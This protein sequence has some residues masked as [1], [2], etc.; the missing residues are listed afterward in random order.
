ME[1]HSEQM[2]EQVRSLASWC[3][4]QAEQPQAQSGDTQGDAVFRLAASLD[5]VGAK[6][7]ERM[8]SQFTALGERL[9]SVEAG[10]EEARRSLEAS[11]PESN[12]VP[13]EA[14][15]AE[16]TPI[17]V[18]VADAPVVEQEEPAPE[19]P[20]GVLDTIDR[21]KSPVSTLPR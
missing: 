2:Q 16:S 5:K 15:V 7:E 14:P 8:K 20:L 18:P 11:A 1:A 17:D 6:I 10:F 4:S 19:S 9:D 12:E 13:A 3:E 21:P